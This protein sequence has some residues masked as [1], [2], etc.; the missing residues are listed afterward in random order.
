MMMMMIVVGG[1]MFYPDFS[2]LIFCLFSSATSE[3]AERNSTKTDHMLG[4][5][6]DLKMD[7]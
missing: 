3:L 7:V 2:S 6:C 5:K 1:L 4:S